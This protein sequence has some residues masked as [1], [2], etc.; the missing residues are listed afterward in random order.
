MESA[1]SIR[2]FGS[3]TEGDPKNWIRIISDK[4]GK[5][6]LIEEEIPN[7]VGPCSNYLLVQVDENGFPNGIYL[8]LPS[9]T[10][11]DH[12]GINYEFPRVKFL[13]GETIGIYFTDG[14][15]EIVKIKDIDKATRPSV[16]G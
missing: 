6:L 3:T 15:A 2:G 10:T 5:A 14:R 7:E 12:G 4:S 9:R 16:P 1:H 11:G 13:Q 8:R